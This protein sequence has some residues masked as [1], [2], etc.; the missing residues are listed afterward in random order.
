MNKVIKHEI[1]DLNREKCPYC[2]SEDIDYDVMLPEDNLIILPKTCNDCNNRSEEVY[3]LHYIRT[4]EEDNVTVQYTCPSCYEVV[5]EPGQY[6]SKM[7]YQI[8]YE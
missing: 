4:D 7:C 1:E 8:R 5:D 6:C 2:G 3:R